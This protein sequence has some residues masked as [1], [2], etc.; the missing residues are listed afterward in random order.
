MKPPLLQ[1]ADYILSEGAAWL[2]SDPFSVR[3]HRTDE[4]IVVDIYANGKE[5]GD[6]LAS[7][8]AYTEEALAVE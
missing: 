7:A 2:E 8:Y 1:D 3:I 5:D 4:G 6:S